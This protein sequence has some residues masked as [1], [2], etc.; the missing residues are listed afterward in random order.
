LIGREGL[1]EAI[2]QLIKR[3]A[4]TLPDDVKEAL[5]RAYS[6]ETSRAARSQL[7][8]IIENVEVAEEG[9][10]PVC[11]DTGLVCVYADVD[12]SICDP[13]LVE[14]ASRE[15]VRRATVEVP[16]RP[17]AVHPL[18]RSN[19]GDNVGV[20][21]PYVEVDFNDEGVV[22]LTVMLKGAGSENATRLF[23][24]PPLAGVKGIIRSVVDAVAELGGM[25][26]PPLVIGVGVGG[27]AEEALRLAK[28]SLL[29]PVGSRSS[30]GEA[31]RLEEAIL[32]AV[33]GLGIGC[34]GLGGSVTAL[35]VH[36]ELAHCHTASLPVAVALQCWA[37]RRSSTVLRGV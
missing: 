31:A 8:A 6:A 23:M 14:H 18:S 21:V 1:V 5:R 19:T 15:A 17:N 32:R 25:A 34:M 11:Q 29:R 12:P 35:D 13:R 27:V 2:A 9:Q 28:R 26:C 24:L 3:S 20:G 37:L 30:D 36:V 22:R 33:N 7:R 10:V 4:T 16:L